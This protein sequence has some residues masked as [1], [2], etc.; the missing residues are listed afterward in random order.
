MRPWH[1]WYTVVML[2]LRAVAVAAFCCQNTVS[3][4]FPLQFGFDPASCVTDTSGNMLTE[5]TCIPH[6]GGYSTASDGYDTIGCA[7]RLP[8]AD[9]EC[10]NGKCVKFGCMDS[11]A[12]NFDP[13]ATVDQGCYHLCNDLKT[14]YKRN[15]CCGALP[16]KQ[17]THD[18]DR[19]KIPITIGGRAL[20][21]Y[22]S[23]QAEQEEP[24]QTCKDVKDGY[25]RL[26]CCPKARKD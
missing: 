23:R 14:V 19:G 1:L 11:Q 7:H 25:H 2:L 8:M 17:L 12:T 16:D 4:T 9:K 20:N 22:R 24:M 5:A 3:G 6:F 13:G 21:G 15:E 18:L 26:D 10:V